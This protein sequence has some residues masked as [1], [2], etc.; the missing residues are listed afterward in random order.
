MSHDGRLR[1]L[2]RRGMKELDVMMERYYAA[3]FEQAP[4]A[5]KAEFLRLVTLAEDPDIWAWTMGYE[6]V[7]EDYAVIIEQLRIYR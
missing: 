3:R 7:P 6:P 2:L 4:P 1:W 5:E